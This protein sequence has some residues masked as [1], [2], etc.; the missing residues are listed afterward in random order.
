MSTTKTSA[1]VPKLRFPGFEGEWCTHLLDQFAVRGSGHTPS[2]S[3][4]EYYGGEIKWISLADSKRLDKGY[5]EETNTSITEAGIKNSSAVLHPA[6]TVILSRDAGVGKSAVMKRSMAVSQH[7]IAW[8]PI[9]QVSS[10]WFIYYWLQVMKPHFENIAIGNTIKTIGLPYFKKLEIVAPSFPEQQKIA[11]FL[12]AVDG[13]IEQLSRKKALLE[14][15]KKGVMQQLFTQTLRF[16]DDQGHDFPDWEE[17]ELGSVADIKLGKMLDKAKH[18]S[19]R[20]LPYL[21]NISLR[22]NEVDTSNLPQMFFDDDELDRFGLK[23]GDVVVCEGG[24]PG[25]SAVWDGRLLNLKFQKAI[26]RVRFK[27]PFAPR[28]LVLYLEYIAGTTQFE[29]LFTGGGIKHLTR[30]TFAKL[31]VPM[32]SLPEQTK[33]AGF[34]SALDG[35]IAAVGEQMRQTQAWKKGLLQQ[36]FV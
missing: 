25:R 24:E 6:E 20:L 2:K 1:Q 19:G 7:F 22:W 36:M 8:R 21:N 31:A 3:H 34:L 10:S 18:T 30:E 13:L 14:E 15:Y 11:M 27:V 12:T 17:V 23:A 35:K 28:I 9:D 4:P 26:H 29:M 16:Q 33:I 32:M 5:I